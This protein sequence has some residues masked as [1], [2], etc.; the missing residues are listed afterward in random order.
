MGFVGFMKNRVGKATF[1]SAC[2]MTALINGVMCVPEL[3]W[4]IV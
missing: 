1:G 4:Y 2:S 3:C